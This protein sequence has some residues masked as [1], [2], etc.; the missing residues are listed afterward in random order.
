M[1]LKDSFQEREK[2]REHKERE[3][4]R[5]THIDVCIAGMKMSFLLFFLRDTHRHKNAKRASPTD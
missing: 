5:Q 2:E 3:R 4:E 1:S